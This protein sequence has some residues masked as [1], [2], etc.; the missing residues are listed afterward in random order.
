MGPLIKFP[1]PMSKNTLNVLFTNRQCSETSPFY[2]FIAVAYLMALPRI[3][4]TPYRKNKCLKLFLK[5]LSSNNGC[6]IFLGL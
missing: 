4:T 6:I 2:H 5:R 3:V 1:I